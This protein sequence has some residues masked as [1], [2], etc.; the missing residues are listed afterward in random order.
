[1]QFITLIQCASLT[2][3]IM[4]ALFLILSRIH[5]RQLS[6]Q[7]ET[8][9]WFLVL[10]MIILSIHY[11]LQMYFGFRAMGDDVGA[12]INILFYTPGA[13]LISVSNIVMTGNKNYWKVFGPVGVISYLAILGCFVAG[14][15]YYGNL[16]LP[17]AL[18]T[19]GLLF[20][21]CMIFF[22]LAPAREARILMR[23][24]EDETA[25]DIDNYKNYLHVGTWMMYCT[26]MIIPMAI[27]SAAAIA[28]IGI[29]YLICLF[30][31]VV[32]FIALGYNITPVSTV[33]ED[34]DPL[35]FSLFDFDTQSPKKAEPKEE[36]SESPALSPE[37][38]AIIS[39]KIEQWK[40]LKGFSDPDLNSVTL[41]MRLGIP[42]KLF[43]QY[44]SQQEGTTFRIWISNLRIEQAKRML[45]EEEDYSNEFIALECGY[46]SRS[47]LQQKFKANTGMSPNEW[48]EVQ[49]AK[50]SI[51]TSK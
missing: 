48:R 49:K 34:T 31:Y 51:R 15:N 9:R 14:W 41:S 33:I 38:I 13:F 6:H 42:K 1:M 20:C 21:A 5:I 36:E 37:Q 2:F 45:L 10:S 26:A 35:E 30:Y 24:V 28:F 22:I 17:G 25:G 27:Y 3:T 40:E 29:I 19:M 39:Q 11:I 50:N 32:S 4:I 18:H 7:Y 12:L 23:Q 16:H 43:L 8:A 47:W 46:S 44:I